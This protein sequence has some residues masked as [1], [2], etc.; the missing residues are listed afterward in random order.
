MKKEIS[1]LFYEISAV[2]KE[3]GCTENA[4]LDLGAHNRIEL[5]FG[6]PETKTLRLLESTTSGERNLGLPLLTPDFLKLRPEHCFKLNI[7]GTAL[8]SDSEVGY[9]FSE[10]RPTL[11]L[12]P[13]DSDERLP[14]DIEKRKEISWKDPRRAWQAWAF[15]KDG[16]PDPLTV[17]KETVFVSHAEISDYL[18]RPAE[19]FFDVKNEFNSDFL[20]YMKQAAVIFWGHAKVV[21]AKPETHPKTQDIEDW[22]VEKEMS[23][24]LAKAAASLI[25]P[26]FAGKGRPPEDLAAKP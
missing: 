12:H 11:R 21:K 3:L 24:T 17:T 10:G 26:S 18:R 9:R 23:R 4:L 14:F 7:S 6:I 2:A 5:I 20:Q 25:R 1:R 15:D 16:S 22:F 13:T 8:V 19:G